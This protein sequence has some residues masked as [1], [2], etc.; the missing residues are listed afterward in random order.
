MKKLAEKV[1]LVA[2]LCIGAVFILTTV[3]YLTNSI[4][5]QAEWQV[6]GVLIALMLV[7]A[8]VFAGIAVYLLY[9]NF[10]CRENLKQILLFCDS[11]SATH[12]N[13]KVIGNIVNGCAKQ[14]DGVAVRKIRICSD[15]KGGFIATLNVRVTVDN[16]AESINKL[17]C[18]LTESFKNALG[19]SFNTINFNIERIRGKY[20][21]NVKKAE[22]AAEQLSKNQETT[23]SNYEKPMQNN[24]FDNTDES[25]LARPINSEEERRETEDA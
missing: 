19:L 16:V 7:L 1:A 5:Q 11:E 4:P 14:V 18:L 20:E 3:L 6:N 10:S 23:I 24:Y 12:T 25:V 2:E 9:V 15:E 17:R 8:A 22:I 21:P 13:T